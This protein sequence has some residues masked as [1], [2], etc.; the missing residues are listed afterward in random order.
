MKSDLAPCVE[1]SMGIPFVSDGGFVG[2][3]LVTAD[4]RGGEAMAIAKRPGSG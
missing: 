4:A 3:V 1:Q 2:D